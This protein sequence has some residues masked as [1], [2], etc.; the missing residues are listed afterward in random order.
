MNKFQL[1]NA[2]PVSTPMCAICRGNWMCVMARLCICSRF[3]QNPGN[4]HWEA[5][6][7]VMVYLRSTKDLWLTFG[8]QSQKLVEGFCNSD[9]ANQRD[10]HS[11]AGFAYHFREGAVSWNLKKQ[12]I[13]AL[14]T[15]EAE[16]IVQAHAVKEALW[17]CT[18]ISNI[19]NEP[20]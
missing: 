6:K 7:Q 14:S 10:H 18:F 3:I 8:G 4:I 15:V 17:L 13:I 1:T 9:H 5:P 2:K 16:Y 12:Q 20:Y 11:I 19:Q